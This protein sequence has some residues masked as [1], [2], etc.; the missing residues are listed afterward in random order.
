MDQ[1]RTP[2]FVFAI[3]CLVLAVLVEV[4]AGNLLAQLTAGDLPAD[5]A[6]TP[7]YAINYIAL[8]D[9]I[10]LYS[11]F[12]MALGLFVPRGITGRVQGIITLVLSFFAL[13][14]TIVLIIAAFALLML[15]ITLLLAVPFGT[16]AYLVAWGH[17]AVSAAAATLGFAMLLKLMFCVFLVLAQQRFLENKGLVILIAASLGLTWVTGFVQAFLPGFLASIGDAAIALVIA[18]VAAIWLLVLLIGS[19]IAT[20]KAIISLKQVVS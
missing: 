5:M 2:F 6:N 7:G 3:F 19:I 4:A 10:L 16:I 9:G 8:L 13:L 1:L 18:V 12:W 17:F 20:I 11:L 14:G 15:M